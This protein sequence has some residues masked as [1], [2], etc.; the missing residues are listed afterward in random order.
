MI[1]SEPPPHCT[2]PAQDPRACT[3]RRRP[4]C[5]SAGRRRRAVSYVRLSRCSSSGARQDAV[6]AEPSA[7]AA[8]ADM[9]NG[10]GRR[11]GRVSG[12]ADR[13]RRGGMPRTRYGQN[14]R[15]N[16]PFNAA[17]HMPPRTCFG[18]AAPTRPRHIFCSM[19]GIQAVGRIIRRRLRTHRP[20]KG[21]GMPKSNTHHRTPPAMFAPCW[22]TPFLRRVDANALGINGCRPPSRWR[23]RARKGPDR[24]ALPPRRRCCG[25]ACR[26]RMRG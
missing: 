14:S 7:R 10:G 17:A 24:S 5:R 18:G 23:T 2:R 16:A 12:K 8:G 20:T 6:I 4:Q 13:P 22:E 26:T 21:G 3:G 9:A 11:R 19:G 1:S 15:T 25:P